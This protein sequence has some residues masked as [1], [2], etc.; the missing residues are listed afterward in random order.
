MSP[1]PE[2]PPFNTPPGRLLMRNSAPYCSSVCPLVGCI[3]IGSIVCPRQTAPLRR[4]FL[5]DTL[6]RCLTRFAAQGHSPWTCNLPT[7]F[8]RGKSNRA[9]R[10]T[11][12]VSGTYEL[13]Q[14]GS[15]M[16]LWD[17]NSSVGRPSV[18]CRW[19]KGPT[20]TA[21]S[22]DAWANLYRRAGRTAV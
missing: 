16:L 5:P 1:K 8:P 20:H 12:K 17:V 2:R 11:H 18:M 9:F 13:R 3:A 4:V 22:I 19:V 6:G 7:L 15:R 21:F 10:P 14:L